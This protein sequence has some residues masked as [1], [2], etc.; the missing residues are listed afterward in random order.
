MSSIPYPIACIGRIPESYAINGTRG[1]GTKE[2]DA[3]LRTATRSR[4]S[5]TPPR[6]RRYHNSLESKDSS[7]EGDHG[8]RRR[9]F[10][11][12]KKSRGWEITPPIDGHKPFSSRILKFKPPRHFIKPTDMKL[13]SQW[14]TSLPAG[15]ISSYSEIRELFLNEFTTSIDNT[16]HPI[17][18]LAVT[19][20][21]KETTRKF[22]ERFNAECKTI[23]GLVDGVANLCLT[24]GL[25][26][27]DF[28][29]QL[30]I[31]TGQPTGIRVQGRPEITE[32]EVQQLHSVSSFHHGDLPSSFG[33]KIIRELR[34]SEKEGSPR[35]ESWNAK[36]RRD[37][38]ELIMEVA[39]ITG[40]SA[41]KSE[42][43][44][45]ESKKTEKIEEFTKQ[46]AWQSHS[47]LGV[48]KQ[49]QSWP[50]APFTNA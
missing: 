23:D 36:N 45:L 38:D 25:A 39:V 35:P 44:S 20:K 22:I 34:N 1:S 40:S 4:R 14:F 5:R 50:P 24:N 2:G 43:G 8:G 7:S 30:T 13:A 47:R 11:R 6:R 29:K 37:D 18:L 41:M 49:P 42:K 9:A 21:P 3:E 15:S 48:A 27:D 17:N 26:R 19:Q 33:K 12:Y 10:R 31:K 32:A 46:K 28:R 16:T